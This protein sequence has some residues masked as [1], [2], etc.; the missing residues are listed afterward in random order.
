VAA[1]RKP[2]LFCQAVFS[3]QCLSPSLL[4]CLQHFV[5]VRRW[6]NLENAAALQG[7]MRRHE[8]YSMI[9]IP[10]SIPNSCVA[11]AH[12]NLALALLDTGQV[13]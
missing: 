4:T 12:F 2:I 13:S 11:A 6:P 7:R 1:Q 10:R 3:E 8:L 9:H 5:Q